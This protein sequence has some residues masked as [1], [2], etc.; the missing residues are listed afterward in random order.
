ME[1]KILTPQDIFIQPQHLKVPLFQRPYVWKRDEQWEPLWQDVRRLTEVRLG[2]KSLAKHF[3]GAIVLQAKDPAAGQVSAHQIIDGQQRL[4]TLQLLTDAAAAALEEMGETNLALQLGQLTH[5]DKAFVAEQEG[6]PL[7]LQ[8]ENDD[9]APFFEVMNAETP[10]EHD[11]LPHAANQIILAHKYFTEAVTEWLSAGEDAHTRAAALA[12][13]I[14]HGVQIAAITLT[15]TEDSQEIFETLNA[16]GTPLTAADL[17][18]NLV[19]QR[20]TAEGANVK[21]AH[22]ESWPFESKFWRNDVSVGRESI[23]RSSR[24]FNHWLVAHTGEEVSPRSTFSRFK[25]YVDE[26]T[27]AADSSLST[28]LPVISKQANDYEAWTEAASDGHQQLS[29]QELA[30]YRIKAS[31]SDMLN[32]ILLW[33]RRPGGAVSETIVDSVIERLEGW[34]VRRQMLR[35]HMGEAGRIIAEIIK[36]H[37]NTPPAKLVAEVESHLTRLDTASTYWPGDDEIREALATEPVYRRLKRGRLRMLL[38]AVEDRYRSETGQPQVPRLGNPIEHILPQSFEENW[39]VHSEKALEIRAEHVHRLGNLT[40]LTDKLNSKVS[41]GAWEKKRQALKKHDVLLINARL[42]DGADSE[43]NEA[44]IDKRTQELIGVLLATWPVP[45]GHLGAIADPVKNSTQ[46]VT[47][48]HLVKAGFLEA[49]NQLAPQSGS[50]ESKVATVTVD[51]ALECDGS[52]FTSPSGAG[53]HLTGTG[54]NGWKFWRLDDGR[55]LADLRAAYGGSD[56]S[57]DGNAFD[58]T[59]LHAILAEIP[60]GRWTT[61]GALADAIGTS[62]V[63]VGT[64]ILRCNQCPNVHR[65]LGAGG[66]VLGDPA[67]PPPPGGDEQARLAQIEMEGEGAMVDGKADPARELD[68]DSLQALLNDPI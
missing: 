60:E 52:T 45:E 39:P 19:F 12:D 4:T 66:N 48:K 18:R 65:V 29:R 35:L 68:G 7:K 17:I 63:A 41:N 62:P 32:P 21:Q 50:W 61:Y 47:L 22:A 43:W 31:E 10:V 28:L 33:L 8:H 67:G 51:G 34:L 9:R 36:A 30:V 1:T 55:T 20:L 5:N 53:E 16:R 13:A 49:G 25:R 42:P 46:G 27:H 44:C 58:W 64:H 23:Q 11:S 2:D 15:S 56:T 57:T 6:G 59:P 54:T 40:L 26:M 24:F 14:Q 38:E 37:Q 3:L